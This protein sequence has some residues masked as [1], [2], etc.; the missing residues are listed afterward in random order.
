M[1]KKCDLSDFHHGMIVGARHNSG[2]SGLNISESD[3][4]GFSCTTSIE[5]SENGVKNKKHPVST[6]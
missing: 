6:R 5:F 3:D 1:G 4:L 2:F